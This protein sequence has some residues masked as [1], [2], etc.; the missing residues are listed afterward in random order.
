MC[1]FLCLIFFWTWTDTIEPPDPLAIAQISLGGLSCLSACDGSIA[2]QLTG[3]TAPYEIDWGNGFTA[4]MS[5]NNLCA[6]PVRLV[7]RDSQGN[8]LERTFTLDAP[9]PIGISFVAIPPSCPGAK[10]GQLSAKVNQSS[11]RYAWSTGTDSASL[12]GL[13]EG[14]YRLTVTN[15]SGCRDSAQIQLS[16]PLPIEVALA[17]E[18]LS[19]R[20]IAGGRVEVTS[21]VGGNGGYQF[22]LDARSFSGEG[23]FDNLS[24]GRYTLTVKDE[25]GCIDS[26]PFGIKP[27]PQLQTQLP[28]VQTVRL[29]EP[30]RIVP[31]FIAQSWEY[32]WLAGARTLSTAP[33]LDIPV[34]SSGA[35]ILEVTDPVSD[36]Q[37]RDTVQVSVDKTRRVF[38]PSAFSPNG[39]GINETFVAYTGDDV[40]EIR[41]LQ[42]YNRY[43]QLVFNRWQRTSSGWD[44]QSNAGA[45][46][47]NGPYIFWAEILF[48]DGQTEIFKGEV[49]L[50]R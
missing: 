28:A 44:G 37:I 21:L 25:L 46:L 36:C 10:D 2:V 3:G 6:G 31:G 7:V 20:P 34:Q 27:R 12:T 32:R 9:P 15:A 40:Q 4:Q 30:L 33:E 35:Y 22:A 11:V 16:G 14:L 47:P 39:D 19:C 24:P 5:R 17:V 8:T 43:G 45:Q 41:Q 38:F 48:V 18:N 26:F 49:N 29:G 13:G 50:M 42:I 1:A 23:R